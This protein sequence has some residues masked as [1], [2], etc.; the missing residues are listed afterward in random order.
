M[1]RNRQS[2][3]R[4]WPGS[5]RG[6]AAAAL[7]L[8]V[9]TATAATGCS[10]VAVLKPVAGDALTSVSNATS[11]VLTSGGVEVMTWP[12]CS[13]ADAVYTCRGQ[14]VAGESIL[15]TAPAA[16]PLQLTVKVGERTLYQ[17]PLQAV[18]DQAGRV[19][20]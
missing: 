14:T 5:R 1:I 15:G 2:G 7:L 17:G 20:P 19:A 18:L 10:Q 3:R 4:D 11:D 16:T 8:A 9:G 13:F 12:V 6:V